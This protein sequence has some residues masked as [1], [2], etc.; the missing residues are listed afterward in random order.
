MLNVKYKQAMDY[1]FQIDRFIMDIFCLLLDLLAQFFLWHE[2]EQN[3][4]FM[5]QLGFAQPRYHF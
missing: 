5:A 1:I 2:L 4:S 3:I